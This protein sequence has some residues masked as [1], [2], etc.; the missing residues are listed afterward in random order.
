[1]ANIFK[2]TLKKEIIA[3][4][5]DNNK[6]EVRFPIT[7]FWAT[8]FTDKYNLEDKT[9]EFKT[10]DSLELSSPSNKETDGMT[11]MFDFVRTYV[12]GDEFVVEFKENEDEG[13]ECCITED[14]TDKLENVDE[15][16]E[17]RDVNMVIPESVDTVSEQ[18]V[19]DPI[20]T[21][22]DNKENE[23]KEEQIFISNDEIF[24]LIEEWFEEEGVLDT[25]YKDENV[26]ATNARQVIVLPK[27]GVLGFKKSLP[28]NN[29]VEVRIK[30]D[31]NNRL[32]F[33]STPDF[34][35]FKDEILNML[36]E[37][38]RNNFVFVWKR[39]TGI[40]MD[41][42]DRVYFGIKY[43]TRKSIGLDRKYNVQ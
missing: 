4:I 15:T 13:S 16:V 32:Y 40:F 6:R 5:A 18:I 11:Y 33:D 27:G 3:D 30:F 39:N 12:D 10:F 37:I 29:D 42:D 24:A 31:M 43:S 28:L 17:L 35:T 36:T 14:L 21:L 41:N 20:D 19:I 34:D 38:K 25:F 26:F 23:I 9:F 7:K 22:E 8:R 1:M 2:T